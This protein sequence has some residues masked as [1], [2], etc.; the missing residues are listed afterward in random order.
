M[1]LTNDELQA[2]INRAREYPVHQAGYYIAGRPESEDPDVA[3]ELLAQ[4]PGWME[5]A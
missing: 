1:P 2:A 5:F 3:M 4:S